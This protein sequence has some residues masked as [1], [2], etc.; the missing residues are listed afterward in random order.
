MATPAEERI[1]I[2]YVRRAHGLT[3][4]V[5]VRSLSD[6]P[7]RFVPGASFLTDEDPPRRVEVEAVR[8]HRE[9]LLLALRGITDRTA[10]EGLRGV[11]FTISASERRQLDDD[12]YWPDD[13]I[14]LQAVD[15]AGGR[16][17]RVSN[18]VTGVAQDRLVVTTPDGRDVE[19]PFVAAIVTAVDVTDGVAR[20]DPPLGLF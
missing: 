2:G 8:T 9:G 12:E 5:L 18:V 10:A 13:L 4:D 7:E 6:D 14:G 16:L 11:T 20:L 19:V 15:A 17:G 1:S 3:G